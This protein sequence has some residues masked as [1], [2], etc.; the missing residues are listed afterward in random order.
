MASESFHLGMVYYVFHPYY[1]YRCFLILLCTEET[2]PSV[3]SVVI[4][5]I[6]QSPALRDV[7]YS[8]SRAAPRNERID[9]SPL[10]PET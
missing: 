2:A 4:S 7:A 1:A 3:I 10:H 5:P 6:S 8:S 9:V